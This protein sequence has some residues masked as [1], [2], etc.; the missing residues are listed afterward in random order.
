LSAI[1]NPNELAEVQRKIR[2]LQ[3]QSGAN[4]SGFGGDSTHPGSGADSIQL[5]TEADAAGNYSIAFGAYA[6]AANYYTIVIGLSASADLADGIAIGRSAH[7]DANG[8]VALGFSADASGEES[9]AIGYL[10]AASAYRSVAIGRA[11]NADHE[12]GVAIGPFA[13]TA[14]DNEIA[15]GSEDASVVV[16]GTFSNPSARRLKRNIVP[17]PVL[18]GV[19][20]ELYE[21]EYIRGDG[22]RRIGP[23]ADELVG[24]DA[25]RFLTYDAE[26]RVAGIATQ[27]LQTAQI[28]ELLARLE[29]AE[30]RI[31]ELDNKSCGGCA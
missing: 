11:A 8:D 4:G 21:W 7:A 25:E 17:A 6:V 15:V 13:F 3:T 23:I 16:R 12:N 19:F 26:G 2:E 24:T 31:T 9:T 10:S 27:E 5:G 22:R 1:D 29:R 14:A 28:A 30:A 18:R 20:P